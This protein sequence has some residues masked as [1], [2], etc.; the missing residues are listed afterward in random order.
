M[1][2]NETVEYKIPIKKSHLLLLSVFTIATCGLIYELIAG[3]LASYLLGDSVTQFSTI[4]GTYLFAMGLGSYFSRFFKKNLIQWFVNVEFMIALIGGFSSIILFLLFEQVVYFRV[5]LYFLVM[6]TGVLVGLEIPILMRLLKG[7]FTFDEL[8]SEVFTFDYIGALLASLIFPLFFVPYVGLMRTSLFFG[9]LNVTVALWIL[10]YFKD[11]LKN[12][13]RIQISG[14]FILAV[15]VITFAMADM[16]QNYTERL[17]YTDRLIISKPSIYQKI[18]ITNNKGNIKLFLNG[19]LQ[20]SSDDE[21]RYHE[22]LVHPIM[23]MGNTED[24]VVVLGGGDG[25]AVRELLKY[26]SV[27]NIKLIDLDGAVTNL[28]K[29]HPTLTRLNQNALNSPKVQV[30]NSDAYVWCREQSKTFGKIII[31][32]PDPSNYSVGKL[33]SLSFYKHLNKILKPNGMAVIQC[34]SPYF[35]PKS[36][37]CINETLKEAGFNTQPYHT[38]VPS[39]GEWGFIIASKQEIKVPQFNLSHYKFMSKEAYA[40]MTHFAPDMIAKNVDINR[41]NNQSLVHYFEHEWDKYTN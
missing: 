14:W 24:S 41:L 20:F 30:L 3:T 10:H 9:I 5:I 21:Y 13:R 27:K 19:N 37:W 2:N 34:T 39:F 32:F 22:S 28:F 17:S 36:F 38:Y 35:A 33:Y 6:I 11:E 4:I 31:D 7:N 23:A 16:I 8:V 26:E 18:G 25:L 40:N 15:L 1:D 29:T 12:Y